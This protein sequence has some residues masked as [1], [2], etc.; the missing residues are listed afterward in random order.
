MAR[1]EAATLL[2]EVARL[3]ADCER[4]EVRVFA[5]RIPW[6]GR[7]TV[8]YASGR[9]RSVSEPEYGQ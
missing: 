4:V 6:H 8:R 9:V 1:T 7:F 3:A 5:S 2:D